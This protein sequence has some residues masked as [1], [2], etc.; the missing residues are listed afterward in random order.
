MD[1][2]KLFEFDDI[3]QVL[4]T[5][6]THDENDHPIVALRCEYNGVSAIPSWGF[7]DT[8]VGLNLRDKHFASI[9]REQ[10]YKLASDVIKL[11]RGHDDE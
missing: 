6:D 9:D 1:F 7:S 2:A 5:T 10:A 11:L 3:G 4:I 8:E